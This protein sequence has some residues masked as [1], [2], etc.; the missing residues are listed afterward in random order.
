M[1]LFVCGQDIR[2]LS[3]GLVRDGALERDVI[4]AAS[5]EQ[6]LSA[7]AETLSDWK[8]SVRDFDAIAVVT[9]P[10]SFTS[11]RVSA[12]IANVMAFTSGIPIFAIENH[13]RMNLHDLAA[14]TDFSALPSVGQYAVPIY[15][16]PPHIT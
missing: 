9:G 12:T 15:D 10:G 11:S 7:L 8:L 6:Y 3:I 2:S 5:P 16:R 13:E 14:R 1:I 4:V